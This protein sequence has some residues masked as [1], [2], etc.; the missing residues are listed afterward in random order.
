MFEKFF[1]F[2][3]QKEPANIP[4]P[5][6]G[7]IIG[8][9]QVGLA[10]A[11]SLMIQNCFDELVLQDLNSHQV[12]EEV[13]DLLQGMS[14]MD[15]TNLVGGTVAD[16]GKEAD[17]VIITAGAAQKSAE[18]PLNLLKRNIAI[19]QN[20]LPD[21][22]K[23]CPEAILLIVTNPV[24]IMTYAALK[25]SGFP[26]SRV[27]GLGTIL[28][29]SRFRSLLANKL[30]IDAH[31]INAYIIGEHG[32][33]SDRKVPVWS[34]AN[35]TD[36]KLMPIFDQ[37]KNAVY[38]VIQHQEYTLHEIGLVVTNI[39]KAILQ[40]QNK[41]LTVSSF[42]DGIYGINDVCLGLP[43]II[44]EQGILKSV[45]LDLSFREKKQLHHSAQVLQQVCHHLQF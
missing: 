12:E 34:T 1:T 19:Y 28:D 35:V 24:D 44:N 37:V 40:S 43:R 8:L 18:T 10:C 7:V 23:H 39:V 3:P 4:R 26:S 31:S 33:H 30:N 41:V 25:I 20:I 6:K 11:Y 22:V 42:V 2:K 29:T 14:G 27:I 36:R 13:T 21:V 32:E 9:D 15:S 16:A 38:E 17:I 5:R 45:D